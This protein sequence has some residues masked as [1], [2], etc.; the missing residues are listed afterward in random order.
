[1]ASLGLKFEETSA[2]YEVT[3]LGKCKDSRVTILSVY[4]GKPVT[5]VG[6]A[7]FEDCEHLRSVAIPSSVT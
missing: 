1:M 6:D 2:G 7:A 3:G 4:N 5:A